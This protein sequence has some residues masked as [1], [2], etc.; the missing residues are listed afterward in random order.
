M[1]DHNPNQ[2]QKPNQDLLERALEMLRASRTD[3]ARMQSEDVQS[4]IQELEV[5]QVQLEMQNEELRIA[6]VELA[7]SRDRYT[8]LYEFAPVGYL[9]L[10]PRGVIQEANLTAATI[11]GVERKSLLSR[12]IQ[13]FIAREFQDTWYLHQQSA[14]FRDSKQVCEL[15]FQKADGELFTVRVKSVPYGPAANLH[16]RT[17]LTDISAI[18]QTRLRLEESEQRY[19]RLAEAITDYIYRVR[20]ERVQLVE[21][22]HGAN[23]KTVT[24]YLPQ[25]F[26][27]DP[28]LWISIV[29][30]EDRPLVEQQAASI[31]SGQGAQTIEHRIQ[32]KDGQVRWVL[33]T[34]VPDHD[35][36][37]T[38]IA[39][40]GLI[41]DVTDRKLAE[42]QLRKE[43]QQLRLALDASEMGTWELEYASNLLTWDRRQFELFGVNSKESLVN[44]TQAI[45]RIHPDDQPRVE[46]AITNSRERG[47]LFSEEFRV[48]HPDGATRWLVGLGRPIKE[49]NGKIERMIGVNLDV[50]ARKQAEEALRLLN[51]TLEQRVTEKTQEIKLLAK[52]MEN[53]G[54]GVVITGD[55]LDWPGP[56]ILFVNETMCRISG[57]KADELIGQTPRILQGRETDGKALSEMKGKLAGGQPVRCELRNY[58]KDGTP[59]DAEIFI[60]PLF[61]SDGRRTNFVSIHRDISD[62]VLAEQALKDREERMR[63]ILDTATSAIFTIDQSGIL[64]SANPAAEKMFGYSTAEFLG[65]NVKMLMPPPFREEHDHYI[66]RYLESGAPRVIGIGR[67][68]VG[69][70]KNG[71]TFP[72]HITVSQISQFG[73]F[74]GIILDISERRE[75]QKHVLEIAAEEQQRIAQELHDGTG[76]ELTGVSLMAGALRDGLAGITLRQLEGQFVRQISEPLFIN[77]CR[78]AER[79]C[80]K[81]SDANR[82]I[83]QLSHGIMPVQIDA[84]GLR[85]ALQDLAESVSC[86]QETRCRFESPET[87]VVANNTT[88]THLYRIA[89]EAVN[90][91]MRHS[92][93]KEICITLS[94]TADRIQ[95]QVQ[96]NGIGIDSVMKAGTASETRGLGL[97][98]MLYRAGMIGGTLHIEA[99]PDHRGTTVTCTVLRG[100]GSPT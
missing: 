16:F 15:G 8:E 59:Y 77:L 62:R 35:Q 58:R 22:I 81:L 7:D 87:V 52:A 100:W 46:S 98:T 38:L 63:A 12:R 25:E 18:Y 11:L 24:G 78:I 76:Q 17:V 2:E 69:L 29:P 80:E 30:E 42:D 6:Q 72:L 64:A 5:H 75:L 67:E 27:D 40:D 37:G 60:T 9:T 65:Q 14:H 85:S 83:H 31:L 99:G 19:R 73:L 32:R 57:F 93:A 92:Q 33:N 54:E 48:I 49:S 28:S 51:K 91:A 39:Y 47:A 90:N 1:A 82:H 4:L 53:L 36:I 68:L 95:L 55:E 70:R 43:R 26:I 41:R 10:D 66:N 61:D 86:T 84:E 88:A 97:R 13:D 45:A 21:T 3:V 89:Q 50:T 96:D 20:I 34:A 56:F 79:L 94:Q 44:A 23:C 74:T 71:E